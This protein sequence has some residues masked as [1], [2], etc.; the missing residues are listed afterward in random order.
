MR[1]D[2]SL[3]L[4][5][6]RA[7]DAFAAAVEDKAEAMGFLRPE[8]QVPAGQVAPYLDFLSQLPELREDQERRARERATPLAPIAVEDKQARIANL[9]RDLDQVAV[10]QWSH[11]GG[12]FLGESP[13]HQGA[14]F[15]RG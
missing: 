6:L 5:D 4:A 13:D 12:L 10:R 14:D 7:L 9:I 15:D 3:A 8:G 11:P 2:D 1:G